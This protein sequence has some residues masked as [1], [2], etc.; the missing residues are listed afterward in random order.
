MASS[1]PSRPFS[2]DINAD[3]KA[4]WPNK[5]IE[6]DCCTDDYLTWYADLLEL[7]GDPCEPKGQWFTAFLPDAK[8]ANSIEKAIAQ[9]HRAVKD[10]LRKKLDAEQASG[11]NSG[12]NGGRN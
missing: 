12:G 9:V 7:C 8:G 11:A 10:A 1:Q 4:L 3:F 6:I 2:T 5:D